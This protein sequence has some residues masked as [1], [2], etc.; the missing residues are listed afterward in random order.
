MLSPHRHQATLS[1]QKN[2]CCS[3]AKMLCDEQHRQHIEMAYSLSSTNK[4]IE[5]GEMI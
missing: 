3:Y 5:R 4:Q 2:R 1:P